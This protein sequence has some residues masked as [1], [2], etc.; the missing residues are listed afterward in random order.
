MPT[1][2]GASPLAGVRER[3]PTRNGP[4][5]P[6]HGASASSAKPPSPAAL[7]FRR[8]ATRA[9]LGLRAPK[10]ACVRARRSHGRAARC[11][12]GHAGRT[13]S[14]AIARTCAAPAHL[15][16]RSR[17]STVV[18]RAAPQATDR[19][20]APSARHR[21][22]R[23]VVAFS[24]SQREAAHRRDAGKRFATRIRGDLIRPRSASVAILLVAW[25]SS[26]RVASPDDIPAPSSLTRMSPMPPP[27]TSMWM[28]VAPASDG[29]LDELLGDA[30]G[31]FDGFARGD[32]VGQIVG[33][34]CAPHLRP[35][36]TER[37]PPWPL[38]G[39]CSRAFSAAA[40]LKKSPY[41][42]GGSSR[43]SPTA[44]MVSCPARALR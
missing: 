37:G 9:R 23:I 42:P 24:R 26:A 2:L 36:R 4:R 40:E 39:S 25:R 6:R 41:A 43:V 12:L 33:E 21:G 29:V 38:Y 3:L 35:A 20:R 16:K 31:S 17:T 14:P 34:L 30:G 32:L 7:D 1:P 18:P 5:S 10:S 28:Q 19:S 8:A 22:A 27:S 11:D 44:R 15:K 13:P